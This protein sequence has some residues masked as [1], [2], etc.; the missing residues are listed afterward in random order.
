LFSVEE[1]I[2]G[3]ECAPEGEGTACERHVGNDE[4]EA[5]MEAKRK[6][7]ALSLLLVALGCGATMA[8]ATGGTES[9]AVPAQEVHIKGWIAWSPAP[10]TDNPTLNDQL[11]FKEVQKKFNIFIDWTAA[12][13]ST[14]DLAAQLGLIIASGDLP[15]IMGLKR[16]AAVQLAQEYGR[17]GA[18]LPLEDLIAKYGPNLTAAMRSNPAYRGQTTS[19]DGHIY[20][21]PRL[22]E[23]L[24]RAF[25]GYQIRKDW[26]DKLQ[27][28][29]P[30]TMAEL[31]TVL[32]AFRDKD[33]NG[34]GAA[35]EIPWSSDPR[36]LIW[37][38]GVGSKGYNN[39]TDMFL[40]NDT[41]KYG[42][43]DPRYKE[44]VTLL[45]RWYAEK[46]I[47][48]EYLGQS[49]SQFDTKV[50]ADRVGACLG[51]FAGYL[52]K[53]NGLFRGEQKS[54]LFVAMPAPAGP[55]G[56]RSMMGSH[57]ETDPGSGA[58]ISVKTKYPAEI[59]RMMDYFYGDEGRKLLFFGAL[60][61]TYQMEG[62]KPVYTEKVTKQPKLSVSQY[63][64]T[65]IGYFSSW[66]SIVPA[67][68]QLQLYDKEGKDAIQISAQTMGDR[69]IPNLQFTADET[70]EMQTIVR[71]VDT[72]V[73]EWLH[74]FIRGQ[75]PM[76]EWA[77]FQE[78][79]KKLN[80]ERLTAIYQ[81]ACQRYRKAAS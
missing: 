9:V 50:L 45:A 65:Y 49:G 79:L 18:F 78:G 43:T 23:P 15:D 73:D 77:A 47:D 40:E 17:Q 31:E 42:P 20:F 76:T 28:P 33:P 55:T 3:V 29:M 16:L 63:L 11:M 5:T 81:A 53:Y 30:S 12:T 25:S 4:E 58:A 2:R 37:P 80:V 7:R 26:L 75:K 67:D 62:G 14:S 38:F 22:M 57:R 34:N 69:K 32:T 72:F 52:T 54:G 74:A 66:P 8:F 61:D 48:N 68:H 44:A 24:P 35:D 36:A 27:L 46:L 60:G 1:L 64:D 70:K 10:V 39:S 13:G 71:D 6:L 59:A 51:S 19:P 21:Y 56:I 41:V